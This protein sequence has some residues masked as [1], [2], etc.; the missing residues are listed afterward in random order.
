MRLDELKVYQLSMDIGEEIW[1]IVIKWS[2]FEKDTVGKQIGK[3]CR[4]NCC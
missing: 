2:Y 4:F 3:S 1:N